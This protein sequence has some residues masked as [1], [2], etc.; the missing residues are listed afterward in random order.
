MAHLLVPDSI[1]Q[2]SLL[3]ILA[4]PHALLDALRLNLASL[5]KVA[6]KDGH[7][8]KPKQMQS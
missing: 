4:C 6:L 7:K 8:P 1:V 5:H 3:S 2:I